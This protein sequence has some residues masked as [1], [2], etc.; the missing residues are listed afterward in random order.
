MYDLRFQDAHQRISVSGV[1]HPDDAMG[2]TSQATGTFC[3][4]R[5]AKCSSIGCVASLMQEL[6]I[7]QLLRFYA[8]A[9][10]P[11]RR[12]TNTA[13]PAISFFGNHLIGSVATLPA[14]QEQESGRH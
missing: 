6:R 3:R 9:L 8:V 7:S 14:W 5:P 11:S 13:C 1:S 10:S 12:S 4:A 2:P